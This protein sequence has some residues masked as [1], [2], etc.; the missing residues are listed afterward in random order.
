[1]KLLALELPENLYY[2]ALIKGQQIDVLRKKA[3]Q[4]FIFLKSC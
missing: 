4:I 2:T 3:I 1:M